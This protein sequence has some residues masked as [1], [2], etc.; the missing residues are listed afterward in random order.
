MI[1]DSLQEAVLTKDKRFDGIFY[2]AEKDINIYH[3]PSC[4]MSR[5]HGENYSF[6]KSIQSAKLRG[7]AACKYCHPARLNRILSIKILNNIDAGVINDKGVRGLARSLHISEQ[8]LRRVV[9]NK[10][11]VSPVYLNNQ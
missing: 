3:R 2:F 1:S 10:T 4:A 7:L 8:H 5:Q 6:F 9:R 11:G